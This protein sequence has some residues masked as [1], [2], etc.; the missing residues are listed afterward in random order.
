M[1]KRQEWEIPNADTFEEVMGQAIAAFT[2]IDRDYLN[3]LEYSTPGWTSGVGTFAV[4][5]DKPQLIEQ[6][7]YVIRSIKFDGKTFET[8]PK[9]LIMS[10][11][12]LTVYFNKSFRFYQPEKLCYWLLRFNPTLEGELDICLLYTSPSPRD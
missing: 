1:Y 4:R 7:R 12:A 11:Y 6:F 8:Y 3:L 10:K 5:S 2:D 9:K